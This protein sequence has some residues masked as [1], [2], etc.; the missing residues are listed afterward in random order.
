MNIVFFAKPVIPQKDGKNDIKNK[1][2]R[3]NQTL[4]GA[5]SEVFF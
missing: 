4:E 3:K 2:Y 5:S 1:K